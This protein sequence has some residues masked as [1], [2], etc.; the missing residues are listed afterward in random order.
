MSETDK[1]ILEGEFAAAN[2]FAIP[3]GVDTEYFTPRQEAPEKNTLV[4]TGSMDWLPNEDAILFFAHEILPK[5]KRRI[6]DIKLV[7]A[8]RRP[9][10]H[11]LNEMQKYPEVSILGWVDDVRPFISRHAVYVVPLRIGGGTR[12]KVYEAMAMGKAIVSTTIGV[13]G[14]PVTAGVNVAIADDPESFAQSVITLLRDAEART[15][16]EREARDFVLK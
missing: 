5:I 7:V 1:Q 8:G 11:L 3:T 4:F 16:I 10:R 14:L 13:E 15:R 2:V 6:P 9:S 12:I